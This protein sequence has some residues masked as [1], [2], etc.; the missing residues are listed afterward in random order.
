M[1]VIKKFRIKN[2]KKRTELLRL[3]RITLH[4]GKRKILEDLTFNLNQ[5]E[6]LAPWQNVHGTQNVTNCQENKIIPYILH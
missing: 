6:I 1:S 5:G 4:F 3:E 2:F